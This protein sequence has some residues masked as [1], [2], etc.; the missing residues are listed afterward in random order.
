[1]LEFSL[2]EIALRIKNY[3]MCRR[4]GCKYNRPAMARQFCYSEHTANQ[5]IGRCAQ[6]TKEY[7][8]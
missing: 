1:M 2:L 4:E 8:S 6:K 5:I 7:I 3:L